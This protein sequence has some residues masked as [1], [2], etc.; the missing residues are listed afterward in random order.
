MLFE[1]K[2]GP[3]SEMFFKTLKFSLYQLFLAWKE[4]LYFIILTRTLL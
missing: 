4:D 2:R 1:G 3:T